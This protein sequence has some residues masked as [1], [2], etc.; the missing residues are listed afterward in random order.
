MSDERNEFARAVARVIEDQQ[1]PPGLNVVHR[2]VIVDQSGETVGVRARD[3]SAPSATAKP[4]PVWFG[5]PGF[6]AQFR[7]GAETTLG[8]DGRREEGAYVSLFPTY[9]QGVSED[10]QPLPFDF[11]SFGGGTQPVAR[12]GDSVSCGSFVITNLPPGPGGIPTGLLI[13]FQFNEN[14]ALTTIATITGPIAILPNPVTIPIGGS[15][16]TGREEF[17]A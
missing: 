6:S 2:V 13:Q 14:T 15:I 3:E 11:I 8:F 5:L 4:V 1:G 17:R 7:A 9:P 12:K 16:Q 10:A